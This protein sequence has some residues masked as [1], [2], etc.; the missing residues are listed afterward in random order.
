MRGKVKWFNREKGFGF[1]CAEDGR[2][3]FVHITDLQPGYD[4]LLDGQNVEFD[5]EQGHKGLKAKKVT[6]VPRD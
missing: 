2:D 3:I 4:T 1:I 5:T 6:V